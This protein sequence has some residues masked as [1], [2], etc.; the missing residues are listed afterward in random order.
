MT[1]CLLAW[2][3]LPRNAVHIY[4]LELSDRTVEITVEVPHQNN[5]AIEFAVDATGQIGLAP[6]AY[7]SPGV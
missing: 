5:G 7:S 3:S 4:R 1:R 6:S 2:W